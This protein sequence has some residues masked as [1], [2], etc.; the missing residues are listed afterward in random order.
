MTLRQAELV[1]EERDKYANEIVDKAANIV[2]EDHFLDEV[3]M[4]RRE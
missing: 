2:M 1:L 3:M 4:L